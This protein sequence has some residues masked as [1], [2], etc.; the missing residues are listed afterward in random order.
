[1]FRVYINNYTELLEKNY[2]DYSTALATFCTLIGNALRKKQKAEFILM[3]DTIISRIV[4]VENGKIIC[5][6]I[7]K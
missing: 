6:L 1:M 5:D 2:E 4:Q 7:K 3:A